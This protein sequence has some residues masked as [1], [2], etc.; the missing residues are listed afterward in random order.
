MGATKQA[1]HRDEPVTRSNRCMRDLVLP[2]QFR[3]GRR[4]LTLSLQFQE[5]SNCDLRT[6]E[7]GTPDVKTILLKPLRHRFMDMGRGEER[8]RRNKAETLRHYLCF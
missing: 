2:C 5:F 3:E 4:D 8:V 1:F 6:W 7:G